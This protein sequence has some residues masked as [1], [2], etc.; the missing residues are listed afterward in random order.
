[1]AHR[2]KIIYLGRE[3]TAIE[4]RVRTLSD[5]AARYELDDATVLRVK[6]IVMSIFEIEGERNH[7]GEPIYVTECMVHVSKEGEVEDEGD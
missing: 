2:K 6:P 3:V 7:L 1:M 5:G 4:H